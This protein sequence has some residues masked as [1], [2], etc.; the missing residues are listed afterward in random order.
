VVGNLFREEIG[1]ATTVFVGP[2][3]IEQPAQDHSA[4]WGRSGGALTLPMLD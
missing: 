3:A 2:C 1:L 4:R